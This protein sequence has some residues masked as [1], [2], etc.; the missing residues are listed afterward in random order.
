MTNQYDRRKYAD[1]ADGIQRRISDEY[2][3]QADALNAAMTIVFLVIAECA[4]LRV[5]GKEYLDRERFDHT[6]NAFNENL[7]RVCA[8]Y[9]QSVGAEQPRPDSMNCAR[10]GS[11]DKPI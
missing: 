3:T 7:G 5:N 10:R 8:Q 9:R 6:V 2:E 4:T 11:H 1:F